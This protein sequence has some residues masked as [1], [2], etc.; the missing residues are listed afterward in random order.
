MENKQI[1]KIKTF[2]EKIYK[3]YINNIKNK[4]QEDMI[5][6]KEILKEISSL[7]GNFSLK[8]QKKIMFENNT[9]IAFKTVVLKTNKN[10]E[11]QLLL[12][13]NYYDES[14]EDK[15]KINNNSVLF[16]FTYVFKDKNDL[17][18]N[19]INRINIKMITNIRRKSEK[20]KSGKTYRYIYDILNEEKEISE[21][22][23]KILVK[24]QNKPHLKRMLNGK[25][26]EENVKKTL[27]KDFKYVK[28]IDEKET[29]NLKKTLENILFKTTN[30]KYI[31]ATTAD[32]YCYN[33]E[34]D[35]NNLIND[36]TNYNTQDKLKEN[37][38]IENTEQIF[39]DINNII[40][41][42]NITLYSV[43]KLKEIKNKEILEKRILE[44]KEVSEQLKDENLIKI[45]NNTKEESKS[46]TLTLITKNENYKFK[47]RISDFDGDLVK[48]KPIYAELNS[49]N[50]GIT[51]GKINPKI[52]KLLNIVCENTY[53]S[54][55]N[56]FEKLNIKQLSFILKVMSGSFL[57]M[58]YIH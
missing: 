54:I 40:I 52:F 30:T 38:L 33:N 20:P 16:L 24:S 26:H 10:E 50:L 11:D 49:S 35:L 58:K 37:N 14:G 55:V 43:K 2:F 34:N 21:E 29:N 6:Q 22:D 48:Q 28:K 12:T 15:D 56:S 32:F 9:G 47:I 8:K 4:P 3:N 53:E 18:N 17:N 44:I 46:S 23:I 39:D 42:N 1:K 25:N 57:K 36:L 27:E 31:K 7:Y 41:K 19:I 51:L 13:T 45:I 5:N